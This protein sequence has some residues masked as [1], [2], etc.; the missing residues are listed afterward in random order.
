M[1]VGFYL[2]ALCY[3]PLGS[4]IHNQSQ[5]VVDRYYSTETLALTNAAQGNHLLHTGGKYNVNFPNKVQV[6]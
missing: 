3:T 6:D 1:L 4:I 2:R 5:L